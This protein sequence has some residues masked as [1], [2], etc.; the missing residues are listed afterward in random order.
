MEAKLNLLRR[1]F[2]TLHLNWKNCIGQRILKNVQVYCL[3]IRLKKI[4]QITIASI[5]RG[6]LGLDIMMIQNKKNLTFLGLRK[7]K[8]FLKKEIFVIELVRLSRKNNKKNFMYQTL[9]LSLI[10][11]NK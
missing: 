9:G 1:N 8:K 4:R 6:E 3:L 7:N 11:K 2:L 5:Q 10:H